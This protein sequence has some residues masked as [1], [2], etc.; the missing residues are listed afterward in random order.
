MARILLVDDEESIRITVGASIREG[1]HEVH[2]ARDV[3]EAFELLKEHDFDVIVSDIIMPRISGMELLRKIRKSS[4][5]MPIILLTGDPGVNTAAEAVR[6]GAFDYLS[7]PISG[8]TLRKVIRNAAGMKKLNDEKKRLEEENRRYQEHLE[9]LVEERTREVR[10]SEE[11][12]RLLFEE[13]IDGI[14]LTN[15]D[16]ILL[17]CNPALLEL[18]GY[19][20]EQTRK[21]EIKNML[22]EIQNFGNLHTQH[23]FMKNICKNGS[24]SNVVFVKYCKNFDVEL[25]RKD[26]TKMDCSISVI[27]RRD[28]NDN[29]IGYQGIIRDITMRK[30][31]EREIQKLNDE[32][33][34]RIHQRTA[35]LEAANKE[36]ESFAYSVSHDLR[37]PLRGINGFSQAL[38]DDCADRLDDDGKHYLDR[39]C[40][41]TQK[42]GHLIDAMLSLSRV[43]RREMISEEVNLSDMV[44]GIAR[45]LREANPEHEVELVIR[46]DLIVNSD[47]H[48]LGIVM[49]N[50]L[51][52][53]WKFT[54]KITNPRIEFGMEEQE[55]K[56]VFFVRDNGV[57]FDMKY[58]D[59]LFTPF[60]RL[61]SEAEFPGTGIG[62][63]TVHRIIARHGGK[64]WAEAE[65]GKGATIYF[66][67]QDHKKIIKRGDGS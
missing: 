54:G 66:M 39:I 17:D 14:Y 37:A 2:T 42:M 29:I 12:Y 24:V 20:K 3:A 9:E 65:E 22:G 60:Q 13:S 61:H 64:V 19:T 49:E 38:L 51:G 67:L 7:K 28:G 55:G 21:M 34:Q 26:T 48:L 52:N 35:E 57:G 43:T 10:E 53:A 5:D 58:V 56:P 11:K 27:A 40:A 15:V 23:L 6:T 46:E 8:D 16:G 30:Q 44:L 45:E 25:Y 63:A 4:P 18:F 50:L 1:G 47:S 33:E 31:A 59:K 32:L 41:G 36:L 62:L